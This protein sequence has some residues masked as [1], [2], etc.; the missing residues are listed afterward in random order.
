MFV[1]PCGTRKVEARGNMTTRA[2]DPVLALRPSF[3]LYATLL[4]LALT[5]L[6]CSSGSSTNGGPGGGAGSD[7]GAGAAGSGATGGDDTHD[8]ATLDTPCDGTDLTGRKV[9][10]LTQPQYDSV[11]LIG[12]KLSGA[13]SP[14]VITLSYEGGAIRCV[15]HWNPPP[16]SGA[17]S[18]PAQ[19][20]IDV[21][22][23]FATDD[24]AFNERFVIALSS[25][26]GLPQAAFQ[27]SIPEAE[28]VGSFEPML[29]GYED[30]IVSLSGVFTSTETSGNV[31]KSGQ[32]PGQ[33]PTGFPF[34][35][36]WPA[37]R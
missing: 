1:A 28:L 7:G 33:V 23:S 32:P 8:L 16:G 12:E 10:A 22:M 21:A 34:A 4:T 26:P 37:P 14:L 2:L 24:G 35:G 19:V 13:I 27:H 15:P 17:P 9:L 5:G 20:E 11:L 29:D 3:A 6:R 31:G 25:S 30:V 18:M 36:Q